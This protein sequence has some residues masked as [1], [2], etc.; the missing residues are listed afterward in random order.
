[1]TAH[2]RPQCCTGC[3]NK[4]AGR[5]PECMTD[6]VAELRGDLAAL[7]RQADADGEPIKDHV[8][9]H[10]VNRLRDVAIRFHDS[11]QLRERI[12]GV[13]VPV[14]K[15]GHKPAPAQQEAVANITV[16]DGCVIKHLFYANSLPDGVYHLAPVVGE[17]Q[18]LTDQQIRAIFLANGFTIK[19]GQIDLKPYV[20]K[21][22][23]ALLAAHGGKE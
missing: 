7:K 19:E 23:R 6:H 15:A 16:R 5:C 8:I 22:A 4:E 18:E 12:A 2:T 9:A 1:M 3:P 11:Q 21:A 13:I 14:L 20:Y 17:R 10:M